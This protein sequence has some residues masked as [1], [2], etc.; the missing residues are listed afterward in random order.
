MGTKPLVLAQY[1]RLSLEDR[2]AKGNL[3]S[4]S[5]S[6]S[7]Q[8]KLID[9]FIRKTPT[10][11]G[12]R[13]VEFCD[14]GYTGTNFNRPQFQEMLDLARRGEINGILVK[15]L[16]RFGR[17]Y[18]E[19]GNYLEKVLPFLRVRV[20]SVN[21]TYDSADPNCTGSLE[22]AFKSLL[23]DLYSKDVSVKVK[24]GKRMAALQG[25]FQNPWAP[26]G[27]V[28]SA[29][30]KSI[31]EV[32][33]EK[34]QVVKRIFSMFLEE[35]GTVQIARTLND[36]KIATRSLYKQEICDAMRWQY[37][38]E[39]N[40]WTAPAIHYILI[41]EHYIG[42]VVY[43]RLK[44]KSL[45]SHRTVKAP[46]ESVIVVPDCHEQII[47]YNDFYKAQGLIRKQNHYEK[48]ER[49][50]AGK[51]KCGIC[52]HAMPLRTAKE[53]YFICG[54]K[55]YASDYTCS[56]MR[57]LQKDLFDILLTSLRR[58]LQAVV[59]LEAI[60]RAKSAQNKGVK[61]T[62]QK[63]IAELE[64]AGLRWKTEM[65][66]N[67]ER[68]SHGI[69]TEE[70]FVAL[71]QE[72]KQKQAELSEQ[73]DAQ[74]EKLSCFQEQHQNMIRFLSKAQLVGAINEITTEVLDYFINEVN[75]YPDS[76]MQ[77]SWS[78]GDDYSRL[79]ERI[80]QEENEDFQ[81]ERSA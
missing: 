9:N 72:S 67:F 20:I 6:I 81:K 45:A 13:V 5:E 62:L 3:K 66:K 30:S 75:L 71:Q 22:A 26:Y 23:N 7:G 58:Q 77:I 59:Q 10:L 79:L 40:Y 44:A 8:R 50:L 18:I 74:K 16:S 41:D 70:Q 37:A 68:F 29:K 34:A 39:E 48:S 63:Q 73:L 4:E 56:D 32:D 65:R 15:D 1:L 28:K 52:G 78:F 55:W 49:P 24:N 35:M 25:K 43:G 64:S 47:S 2:D 57:Y 46:T 51:I 17:N 76:S 12:A 54:T 27:Y 42:S 60:I 14:D 53:S 36:E 11:A 38:G 31:L 21:D 19:V 61:E 69:L 80:T 33:P